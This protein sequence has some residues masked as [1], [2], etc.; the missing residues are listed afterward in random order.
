MSYNNLMLTE[1][2]AEILENE[3]ATFYSGQDDNTNNYG[4]DDS[5]DEN[6]E[7]S[8]EEEIFDE[9][10]IEEGYLSKKEN[11][12]YMKGY[13]KGNSFRRPFE[14]ESKPGKWLA[15]VKRRENKRV[16]KMNKVNTN[17][18]FISEIKSRGCSYKKKG[19]TSSI[20]CEHVSTYK[21]SRAMCDSQREWYKIVC[22]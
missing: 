17:K 12:K 20:L 16:R 15:Q 2:E 18:P 5:Y 9:D 21:M 3:I 19:R 6:Y 7:D 14:P 8:F 4:V 11:R 13:K 1:E 22:K 10:F